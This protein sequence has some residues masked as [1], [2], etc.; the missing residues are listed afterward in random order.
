MSPLTNARRSLATA[1]NRCLDRIRPIRGETTAEDISQSD[2]S[3]RT[4]LRRASVAGG[5]VVVAGVTVPQSASA[6]KQEEYACD[7]DRTDDSHIPWDTDGEYGGWGGHDYWETSPGTERTP[8]VFVH[9]NGGEACNYDDAAEHLFEHGWAGDDL[10]GISFGTFTAGH[11][12]MKDQLDDFV[13][14]VLDETGATE[15]DVVAHSVGVT[16]VRYWLQEYDRYDWVRRFVGMSG[17]NDGVCVCPGCYDTTLGKDYDS[18]LGSGELCEFVAKQCLLIP[19]HPLLELNYPDPTPGDIDYY[20]MRGVYDVLYTCDWTSPY[21]DGA[22]NDW[23]ME[24][25]AGLLLR[26]DAI[27][28]RLE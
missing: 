16:G 27:R 4:F 21:L 19:G 9:G 23:F 11:D 22:Q 28:E 13:Q 15:I 1:V 17:A 10:W 6:G 3:R 26:V 8:V 7:W 5:A 12:L 14:H 18:W 20:M 2:V 25:H 24:G